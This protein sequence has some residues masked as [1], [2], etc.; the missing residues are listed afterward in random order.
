MV[1]KNK[2][3]AERTKVLTGI[4]HFALSS[5]FLNYSKAL[6][7]LTK[8][9]FSLIKIVPT[10]QECQPHADLKLNLNQSFLWEPEVG[11]SEPRDVFR[12]WSCPLIQPILTVPWGWK[13]CRLL[14]CPWGAHDIIGDL[15]HRPKPRQGPPWWLEG[16]GLNTT[17]TFFE[18]SQGLEADSPIHVWGEFSFSLFLNSPSAVWASVSVAAS[19]QTWMQPLRLDFLFPLQGAES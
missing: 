13:E 1:F 18:R 14:A 6:W 7:C 17:P 3:E 9:Q 19:T 5:D 11:V 15:D 16:H 4:Y 10:A 8:V 12:V 2:S